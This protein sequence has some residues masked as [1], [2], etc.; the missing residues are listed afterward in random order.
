MAA[1]ATT[2]S[3]SFAPPPR[4]LFQRRF[5]ASPYRTTTM[6]LPRL[7]LLTRHQLSHRLRRTAVVAASVKQEEILW[8][9][10]PVSV[11]E[12][13]AESLFH[14]SIDLTD[15]P[16]LAASYVS[17]GQ[18]LQVRA[19]ECQPAF[20][21]IASPPSTCGMEMEF[22]IKDIDG[23]AAS[24]ICRLRRGDVVEIGPVM[25]KGFNISEISPP[26]SFSSVLIFATGSGISP[27][28]ALIESGFDAKKRPDVRLYYGARNL[29]RMAYQ[30]RFRD[31]ESSGVKII[32]VLSQPADRWT[33]EKGYVQAAF[34]RAKQ[35]LDPSST[36][37]VLCGHK[38]MA[39][40]ENKMLVKN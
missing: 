24:L 7:F 40:D 4:C 31:W 37:A 13:A 10:A 27:I 1:A 9:R 8:T 18:Y 2:A 3:T 36:G 15:S 25:G 28:R 14:V 17:A 26:E 6:P 23:S 33:G 35:I 34:A 39:E 30:D 32:P 22:L 38:Q 5:H 12:P 16:G 21:A 29:Q 20:L 11:V 19:P